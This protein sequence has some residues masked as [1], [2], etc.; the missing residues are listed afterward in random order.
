MPSLNHIVAG[1]Y[2]AALLLLGTW[3]VLAFPLLVLIVTTVVATVSFVRCREVSHV[4]E[5]HAKDDTIRELTGTVRAL[6]RD[7]MMYPPAP[8]DHD[9]EVVDLRQRLR[10]SKGREDRL[11]AERQCREQVLVRRLKRAEALAASEGKRAAAAEKAVKS[12]RDEAADHASSLDGRDRAVAR[13]AVELKETRE[14]LE[15]ALVDRD[16]LVAELRD[17]RLLQRVL[18]EQVDDLVEDAARTQRFHIKRMT[19]ARDAEAAARKAEAAS[20]M[21]LEAFLAA[22]AARREA[23]ER[24]RKA[25]PKE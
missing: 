15:D 13:K 17:F 14:R 21:Q 6:Q 23:V 18:Q 1:A 2:L 20:T 10:E 22:R 5:L 8:A 4:Q 7:R 16:I 3:I 24:Q 19:A 25:A 11:M 12:L 9:S